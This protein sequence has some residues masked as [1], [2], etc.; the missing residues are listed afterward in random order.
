[1][2]TLA[3]NFEHAV[4]M[5]YIID[6]GWADGLDENQNFIGRFRAET[7]GHVHFVPEVGPVDLLEDFIHFVEIDCGPT[8]CPQEW[9]DQLGVSVQTLTLS[10]TRGPVSVEPM[11]WA[12]VKRLFQ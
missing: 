12:S 9:I 10:L 7:R 4:R 5:G 11:S 8:A 2:T 1:V 3:G 6:Y